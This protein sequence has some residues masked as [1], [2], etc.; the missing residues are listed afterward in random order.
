[1]FLALTVYAW[2][3]KTDFT[4]MGG[5]L[6]VALIVFMIAGFILMFFDSNTAHLLYCCIG[7]ILFS[8]YVIYDT[9]LMLGGDR[10][11][12]YEIDDYSKK[13]FKIL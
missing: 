1:M 8:L 5:A 11:F 13:F 12:T 2:T 6:F 9:Q 4:M 7:V 10:K 3:T